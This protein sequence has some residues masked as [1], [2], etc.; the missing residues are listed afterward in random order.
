MSILHDLQNARVIIEDKKKKIGNSAITTELF[1]TSRTIVNS[2]VHIKLCHK[3]TKK[4][5]Y[6]N[7]NK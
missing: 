1:Y 7:Y 4:K 5:N 6:N 2:E 3:S